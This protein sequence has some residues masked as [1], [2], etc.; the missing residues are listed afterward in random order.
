MVSRLF[1]LAGL[2]AVIIALVGVPLTYAVSWY[3]I[4]VLLLV[5]P[6]AAA[7]I[8]SLDIHRRVIKNT[9]RWNRWQRSVDER[10]ERLCD[11]IEEMRQSRA[12]LMNRVVSVKKGVAGLNQ[13]TDDIERGVVDLSQ[14]H[15]DLKQDILTELRE[16]RQPKARADVVS[17]EDLRGTVRLIQAQYEGR[18]DRAQGSLDDAVRILRMQ[19]GESTPPNADQGRAKQAE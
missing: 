16:I 5:L 1:T 4:T 7:V 3:E 14:H 17:P 11:G 15:A 6:G 18:L 19:L 9:R 10:I 2:V 8:I 12:E 13:A